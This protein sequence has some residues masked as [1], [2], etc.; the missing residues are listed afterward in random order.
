V[1]VLRVPGG[2]VAGFA[3]FIVVEEAVEEDGAWAPG[4]DSESFG[5]EVFSGV[6]PVL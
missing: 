1:F 3:E 6:G 4:A 2:G 5:G